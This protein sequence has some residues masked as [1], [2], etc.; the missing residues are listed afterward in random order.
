MGKNKIILGTLALM[1][2][3]VVG[4]RSIINNKTDFPRYKTGDIRSDTA[5][6]N[7]RTYYLK[8]FLNHSNKETT[9]KISRK[10]EVEIV[11]FT[12]TN[13]RWKIVPDLNYNYYE[14]VSYDVEHDTRNSGKEGMLLI[15]RFRVECY[16][17]TDLIFELGSVV[18]ND[19]PLIYSVKI[20]PE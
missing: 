6:I 2:M 8:G 18:N 3:S 10:K 20:S 12:G 14:V 9:I 1:I 13:K 7:G 17:A 15:Q 16:Q 5:I 4:V 19:N 11:L